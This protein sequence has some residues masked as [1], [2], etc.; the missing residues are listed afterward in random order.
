MK[1]IL[2]GASGKYGAIVL[3]YLKNQGVERDT[4][5]VIRNEKN[6]DTIQEL[7]FEVRIADYSHE[8]ALAKAFSGGERLLFISSLPGGE[9]SRLKHHEN[10]IK[11]AKGAGITFIAYTSFPKADQ[12]KSIVAPD[13]AVTERMI[14]ESGIN[15]AFLRN[16]WY[17]E[18]EL[19]IFDKANSTGI[20]AYSAGEGRVG[21]ALRRE[22]AEAG[23]RIL[24]GIDKSTGI[25]E[26]S[27]RPLSYSD[28]ASCY[29]KISDKTI[30][31]KA[32]DDETYKEF[33]AK[34][35]DPEE[36][37]AGTLAIQND[38]R[39]GGLDIE[40]SDFERILGKPLTPLLDAVNEMLNKKS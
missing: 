6:A 18:N 15:Y 30:E 31:E 17:L 22:Y 16:N 37:I 25:L 27:G 23:A 19:P 32:F 11:A 13:H 39:N 7:G 26:L 28:L 35:G 14:I 33:L 4:I 24:L 2:T 3:K 20:F 5:A 12:S 21:W 34:A 8:N 29:A 40:Q 38:I 36:I 10:V 9:I 1:Y